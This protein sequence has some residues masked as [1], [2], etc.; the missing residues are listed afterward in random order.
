MP[1][2]IEFSNKLFYAPDGKGLY[3]LKQYSENRLEPLM[4]VY[5]QNGYVEGQGASIRNEKEAIEICNKI[6]EI[7][8][9]ERYKG[10]SIGVISLQGNSQSTLIENLLVKKIGE[11]EFKKRKIICGNSASFQGDERDIIILSLVTAH[12]HNRSALTRPEDE[13]RF[14]VAVS[15]AIE[16][17]WL[18]H[19][20]L[21]ED[22]S[23]S[24]DLRYKLLDHFINYQPASQ[25]M[26]IPIKKTLGNQPEPFDSWFEV[27]VHNDIVN[28]GYS[29]KPQY[30]VAKG[31]Y[32]I[33]LVAFLPNG[34]KIAI[35]CDG[36]KWHGAEKY[37]DD[38]MRQKVLERCGW[39]FFRVRGGEYYSNREK[40]MEPL[41]KLLRE[42]DIQKEGPLIKINKLNRKDELITE[43]VKIIQ[44]EVKK[45]AI[46]HH[47]KKVVQPD[48]FRKE[49]QVAMT[50]KEKKEEEGK[51]AKVIIGKTDDLFPFSEVLVFTSMH[52]VYKVQNS[53]VNN[54]E[55]VISEIEFEPN[56]KPIYSTETKNYSGYLIVAFQNGKVGKI[57][58]TNFQTEF[59][60]K[61]LKNAFNSESKLIF[62]EHIEKDIDL[63][64]MSNI[65]KVVL[66]N[67]SKINPVESRNTKGIQ[68][69]KQK[70]NS[71]IIKVKKL[72]QVKLRDAEYY[73][74]EGSLNVVGFYLKQDDVI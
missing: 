61:K 4:H 71:T 20:V 67:T 18:F 6:H 1:E 15:R 44:P 17:I 21:S 41:W 56:E 52:N 39:Q 69:V 9:D 43:A 16:Q 55:Q 72:S 28:K 68:V 63:V 8:D 66:F 53:G 2:I 32:R 12:N 26:P 70:N 62:L 48:L 14:N 22:L 47:V 49:Q 42:N 29:V 65:K 51:E 37:Q 73:R 54:H 57:L 30:E 11:T 35:E 10:K 50:F 40:A 46:L 3:P 58:M 45:P 13:R 33:D 23:N 74:K 31:R 19:S 27:D 7:V 59:N 36:D 60:R 24:N 25:I 38:M 64:A 34:T 5:C